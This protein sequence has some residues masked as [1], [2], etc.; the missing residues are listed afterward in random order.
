V[1]RSAARSTNAVLCIADRTYKN[2]NEA[3][4]A[5]D[6][7]K[8]TVYRRAKEGRTRHE[9]HAYRQAL[10]PDEEKVLVSWIE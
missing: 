8:S 2:P 9:A 1:K 3:S 7:L 10:S 5:T 4:T 6:A